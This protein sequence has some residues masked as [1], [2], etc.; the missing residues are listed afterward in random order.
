MQKI[1]QIDG[2]IG[3][4]LCS[5]YAINTLAEQHE[6]I[7]ITTWPEVF[8]NNPNVLKIYGM[9]RE[10]IWDDVIRYGDFIFPEPYF[11]RAYY[12]QEHHLSQSFNDILLDD[13]IFT[14]P[15]LYLSPQETQWGNNFVKN[16]R[17]QFFGKS[18]I[19]FQPF[20]ASAILEN[21]LVL[22]VTNRSLSMDAV[23]FIADN[24]KDVILVNCGHIAIDHKN[25]WQN[26]F[27]LREL[28]SV[29]A[30]C[31][32][33]FTIDSM[34][35]HVGAA[36]QKTGVL[37]LGATYS[38]NVGYPNYATLQ[39][40]GYPKN[41][42]PNR[43]VGFVDKNK[44]AMDYSASECDMLLSII[45]EKKFPQTFGEAIELSNNNKMS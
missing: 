18:I 43:F 31:D 22:D 30:A 44:G 17:S 19:A 28:F 5:T 33:V 7:V 13:P 8:H 10:Y 41:Y 4:V 45:N 29:I 42:Y 15:K 1:V 26:N 38:K 39:R 6:T 37:L 24:L 35:S 12:T 11:K 14:L 21:G 20:G 3:R 34:L 25:V 32:Y 23:I 27:T 36:F 9:N 2:G 40:D 16:I